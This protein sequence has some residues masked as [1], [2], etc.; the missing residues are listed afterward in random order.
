MLLVVVGLIIGIIV[1]TILSYV[2]ISLSG[3][4]LSQDDSEDSFNEFVETAEI[5]SLSDASREL[6]YYISEENF[7]IGFP[8]KI[9]IVEGVK[10]PIAEDKCG[11]EKTCFCLCK[12]L[13]DENSC[14]RATSIC[15]KL[16]YYKNI[17]G[18]IID[19]DK[20]EKETLSG[21]LIKGRTKLPI[22]I[23]KEDNA[24]IVKTTNTE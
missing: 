8:E 21:I 14:L 5:V 19:E 18:I 20:I 10:R 13:E 4:L 3:L 6:L 24:L 12:N 11:E 16:D 22:A 7:L 15:T 1:T 17:N 23:G 2:G 9:N